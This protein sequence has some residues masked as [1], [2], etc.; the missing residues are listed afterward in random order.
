M[1]KTPPHCARCDIPWSDRR[2]RDEKGKAP[3]DCPTLHY[4]EMNKAAFCDADADETAFAR[5]ATVQEITGHAKPDA[6][7][8]YR[9]SPAKPRIVEIVEFAKRMNYRKLGLI[10]CGGS[11]REG[12]VTQQILEV[13]GFEVISVM[14]KVGRNPKSIYG[15]EPSREVTEKDMAASACNPKLQALVA[16]DARVDFNILLN[17]CVGHDSLVVKHLDAPVTVFSVK[18]RLTGHNP[19]APIYMYDTYYSFLK[20]PL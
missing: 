7:G 20:K 2:C 5:Q 14:C 18:D 10:F 6:Q 12:A 19:L 3:K 15:L 1:S 13:N 8:H 17:L 11:R 4:R 9:F 16:N